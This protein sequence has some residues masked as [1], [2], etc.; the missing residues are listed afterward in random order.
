MVYIVVDGGGRNWAKV[1]RNYK[2]INDHIFIYIFLK[3]STHTI[4]D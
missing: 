3:M 4:V 2:K 1:N